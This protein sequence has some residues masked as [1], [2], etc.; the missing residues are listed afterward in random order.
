MAKRIP[1]A[2]GNG[3]VSAKAAKTPAARVIVAE[4]EATEAPSRL[5]VL[6]TYKLY[7]GGKFPRSE[8]GRYDVVRDAAGN[9][10]ANICR[11][12][13]KDFRDSVVAA[14]A[15]QGGW[16]KRSPY[17]RAQILYR[18]AEM[19]EGRKAQ[20]VEE[21]SA[22]S[23]ITSPA[24][25]EVQASIDRLVYYAG[26]ADKYTQVFSGVN[27]VASSHFN[28]SLHE[29]TGVVGLFAPD[30]PAL[31]GLITLVAATIVG[32]NSAIVLAS[33]ANPIPAITLGEVLATSDLPCGVVNILTGQRAELAEH[34]ASHMDV[35]A[36][37]VA[38]GDRE[39]I[40]K[41][42]TLAANNVKR[43][44]VP[45]IADYYADRAES[46]Y[47][48]LDTQEVKTTWHPVGT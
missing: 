37:V 26:W 8:S 25:E 42:Q 12:S 28:F 29:P 41:M 45:K 39:L 19:L 34:F 27:P 32:G 21:L 1:P 3:H 15:A 47:L 36:V 23:G 35:N 31:L 10:I 17:N 40:K 38:G 46:P 24:L 48:I 30:A 2:N 22:T 13:K 44:I 14:R 4:P 5:P 6:K 33:E 43:V 11:G 16:A 9:A 18:I 20:F 7:V